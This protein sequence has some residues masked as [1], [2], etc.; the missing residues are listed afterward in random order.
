MEIT[1]IDL[2]G[3]CRWPWVLEMLVHSDTPNPSFHIEKAGVPGLAVRPQPDLGSG[4]GSF[5]HNFAAH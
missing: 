4:S 2:P 5:I 3:S 1:P